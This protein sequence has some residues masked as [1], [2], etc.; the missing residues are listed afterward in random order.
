MAGFSRR[1]GAERLVQMFP[2]VTVAGGSA[3]E[4]GKTYGSRVP[5]LIERSIATYAR[6][7]AYR[8]G[9][10]WAAS[11]EARNGAGAR[12]AARS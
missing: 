7:Y 2:E 1:V 11:Q 5:Q 4:R 8:R 6:L 10:D 12:A 3:Y 9:M